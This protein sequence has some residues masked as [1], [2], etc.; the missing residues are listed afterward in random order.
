MDHPGRRRATSTLDAYATSYTGTRD[1]LLAGRD[2]AGLAEAYR[3]VVRCGGGIASAHAEVAMPIFGHLRD[4]DVNALAAELVAFE[5]EA[6]V[7]EGW[8]PLTYVAIF[9]SLPALPGVALTPDGLLDVRS[10]ARL[11]PSQ[12]LMPA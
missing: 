2:P 10:G 1:V 9:L 8:P 12:E 7:P 3:R 4:G 6:V 5:R 11:E